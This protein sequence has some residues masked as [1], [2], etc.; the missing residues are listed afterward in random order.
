MSKKIVTP[1]TGAKAA[2]LRAG[3]FVEI[4]GVIYAA[5]D[6]A[7]R[8]MQELLDSGE[9]LPFEIANSVIYYMGPCPAKPGQVI[10]SAGPT[11]SSRMDSYTPRLIECGLRGSIGKGKRSPEVIEAMMAHQAV[12]FGAIG[13]AGALIA[14]CVRSQRVIA[15]EEL[16]AE[17]LRELVVERFPAVVVIDTLGNNLYESEVKKY[18]QIE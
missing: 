8:R 3:D 11:T 2:E 16:G 13:G 17:A 10:G 6:A 4:S 14:G 15:F 12:Y 5:R 18:R 1:M 7:H 9:P